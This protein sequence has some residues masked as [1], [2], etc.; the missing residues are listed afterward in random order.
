METERTPCLT[1]SEQR[2]TGKSPEP[3]DR[4]VCATSNQE[5]LLSGFHSSPASLGR[6]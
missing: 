4:I 6:T 2:E 5:L 3:A 1:Q